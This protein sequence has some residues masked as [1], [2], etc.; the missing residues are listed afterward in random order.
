MQAECDPGRHDADHFVLENGSVYLR[1]QR[2]VAPPGHF[3][4]VGEPVSQIR[5]ART[6]PSPQLTLLFP[7]TTRIADRV[8][9]GAGDVAVSPAGPVGPGG[10]G[11]PAS[12]FSPAGPPGPM[13]PW[14]P[15]IP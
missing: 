2:P 12:P 3:A 11:G 4:S 14:G 15:A 9:L 7:D 10:P 13:G 8:S 6:S 5:D 1:T